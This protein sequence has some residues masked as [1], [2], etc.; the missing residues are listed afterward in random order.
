MTDI[1]FVLKNFIMTLVLV[2]LMQFKVGGA[3]LESR[4]D[5]WI[6]K[7]EISHHSRVAAAGAALFIEESASQV[8][9]KAQSLWSSQTSSA[10]QRTSEKASK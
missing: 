9:M 2:Y 10:P 6:K 4:F 1:I 5:Q 7:S 3:S 8:K